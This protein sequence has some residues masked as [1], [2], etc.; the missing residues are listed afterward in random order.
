MNSNHY[1][2]ATIAY[3]SGDY[4]KALE[5]FY[6]CLTNDSASFELGDAGLVYHR[7]GNCLVK[8]GRYEEA[9]SVYR[10]SLE[11][12]YYL[13]HGSLHVNL[14]TAFSALGKH[15]EA[16]DE[17]NLALEDTEYT[18]PYR[19]WMG[20]GNALSKLGRIVEAG[21]A[22]RTAALDPS[23]PNP[24]KALMNLGASFSALDRPGDAVEAYLAILDFRVTGN[25]LNRTYERLANAYFAD[26]QYANAIQAFADAQLGGNYQLSD[27]SLT[28]MAQ[29]RLAITA[30]D[31]KSG[32]ATNAFV[33]AHATS[34]LEDSSSLQPLDTEISGPFGFGIDQPSLED[35]DFFTASDAELIAAGK[36]Q[37]RREA[38]L[39]HTGLK[40]FFGIL[41][42]IVIVFG[43]AIYLFVQG[44]GIPTQQTQINGF[45]DDHYYGRPVDQ[46]WVE[47]A[48]EDPLAFA[49]MIQAVALVDSRA[50]T[51]RSLE[52]SIS[53]S[54]AI[55]DVRLA[56]NGIVHY[57][58]SL[59]RDSIGWKING[60]EMIFGSTDQ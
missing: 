55:I 41:V 47:A 39:R 44:Y 56:D 11:D 12:D 21:T 15:D 3:N 42:A 4:I 45:F 25:T 19:A 8:V 14:G 30:P 27:R 13:E 34:S 32:I 46:Y 54:E 7:L 26:G 6:N 29:A 10:K 2:N 43:A 59:V 60:I 38:K 50:V 5:G 33:G 37:Y 53:E 52:H 57:R 49:R 18:T 17:F 16:I 1:T 22:Y 20:L 9:V 48:Q 24:V 23:N 35:I 58:V 31:G 36:R 40:V 28:Q 51:I